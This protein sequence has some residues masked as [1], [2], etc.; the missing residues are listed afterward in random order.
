MVT[1]RHNRTVRRLQWLVHLRWAVVIFTLLIPAALKFFRC[2]SLRMTPFYVISVFL[3]IYNFLAWFYIRRIKHKR[4]VIIDS[5]EVVIFL[6]FQIILDFLFISTS[7]YF[8]GGS[9]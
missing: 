3:C 8:S 5:P 1:Q 6:N 9:L 7:I 4:S 2:V